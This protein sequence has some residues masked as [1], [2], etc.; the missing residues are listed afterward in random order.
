M[1]Y[2]NILFIH[3]QKNGGTY[4]QEVIFKYRS[5]LVKSQ[6]NYFGNKFKKNYGLRTQLKKAILL[7]AL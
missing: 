5:N 4:I 3:C 6:Y 1:R 7:T 2:N